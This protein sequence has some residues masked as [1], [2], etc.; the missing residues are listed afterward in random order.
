MII[1]PSIQNRF[2]FF[3]LFIGLIIGVYYLV[4]PHHVSD[5]TIALTVNK[6]NTP[7]SQKIGQMICIGFSGS[8]PQSLKAILS[9]VQSGSI[10][11][12]IFYHGNIGPE[13]Q[14]R[15]LIQTLQSK[16]A[17]WPLFIA[18]DQ[19]GGLVQ[20]LTEKK[21]YLSSLS[22]HRVA[23]KLSPKQA[24]LHYG[25]MAKQLQRIGFNLNFGTVL[26]LSYPSSII[27][28]HERSYSQ[29][30]RITSLYAGAMVEAH[31]EMGIITALKHFPGHGH[32]QKDTH[33]MPSDIT[34]SWET[35]DLLPFIQLIRNNQAPMIMVGHLINHQF[36]TKHPASLSQKTVQELLRQNYRYNGVVITDDLQMKAIQNQYSLKET[37]IS[38]INAGNDILLF[39]NVDQADPKLVS[40][41]HAII[42]E[43]L[44][45]GDI[46][47]ER[48]NQSFER[49]RR[50]KTLL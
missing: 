19:E 8:E 50:L 37:V 47:I 48:I 46:S 21:G 49:I 11:G 27:A 33:L 5:R 10:G 14:L 44:N 34:A 32:S 39:G 18:V 12:L 24:K 22:P 20:R 41:I 16:T 4:P 3:T 7:L 6:L 36:D 2:L 45:T 29:K 31:Q 17:Q 38:A 25:K 43:A 15:S 23:T 28:S 40:N 13:P 26:D 42:T 35:R 9:Q 1:K 30:P